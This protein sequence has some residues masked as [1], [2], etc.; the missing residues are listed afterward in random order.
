LGCE[1]KRPLGPYG[2]KKPKRSKEYELAKSFASRGE[3]SREGEAAGSESDGRKMIGRRTAQ[4]AATSATGFAPPASGP[5]VGFACVSEAIAG[6]GTMISTLE[7][8]PP[9]VDSLPP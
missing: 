5:S 3:F 4:A 7:L 8:T 9:A 1:Q 6:D 2:P